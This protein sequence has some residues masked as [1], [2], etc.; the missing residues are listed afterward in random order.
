M[1]FPWKIVKNTHTPSDQLIENIKQLLFPQLEL[2]IEHDPKTDYVSKFHVDYSI[3]SN[4]YAALTDLMDGNND[5]ITR[6]TIQKSI[7]KLNKVRKMLE[8]YAIIDEEAHYIIVDNDKPEN[9]TRL[10]DIVASE[11]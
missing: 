11:N 9:K 8:A 7:D 3:D 6:G 2:E 1:H 5:E 10:E 4:L